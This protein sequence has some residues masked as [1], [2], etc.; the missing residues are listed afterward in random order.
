MKQFLFSLLLLNCFAVNLAFGAGVFRIVNR[1]YGSLSD[2]TVT[3]Q[4]DT[5]F[6]EMESLVNAQLTQFDA[7]TY[8]EG[9]ANTT[10]LASAGGTHDLANRFRYFYFSV[11]GGLAADLGG[12]SPQEFFKD[13]SNMSSFKGLSGNMSLTIGAPGNVLRLPKMGWFQPENFKIYMSYSQF[14]RKIESTD[15]DFLSYGLMGQYHFFGHHSLALGAL[16]W[17]GVDVTTGFKY[18]KIKVLFSQSFSQALSQPLDYDALGD[19]TLDMTFANTALLGATAN[20]TTVPLEASTSVGL[21]YCLDAYVGLGT[22]FNFGSAS[23][24]ISA[25]GSVTATESTNTLGVMSGD[26]EFDL[27]QKASAQALSSRYLMG[28]ALDFRVLSLNLQY[29]HN[30]SNRAESLHLSVGAHF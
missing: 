18:N 17:H 3:S 25:P 12:K 28:F 13:S 22:D 15:F 20:I 21:L 4:I 7:E 8:L 6:N 11:G 30:M 29:N 19:P 10:A 27:G 1:T 14:S 26:I 16:K 24:V 23:S 9:T 5:A 2:P